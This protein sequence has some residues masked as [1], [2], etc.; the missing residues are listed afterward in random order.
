MIAAL[1]I[2]G[3]VIVIVPVWF[4]VAITKQGQETGKSN[5]MEE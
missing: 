1:I 3:F 5:K 2:A 4:M